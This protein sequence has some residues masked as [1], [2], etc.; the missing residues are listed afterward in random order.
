MKKIL[1]IIVLSQFLCTSLW[2]AGNAVVFDIVRD[3]EFSPNFLAHLT[4]AVQLGFITG[5]LI[6]A[7]LTIADRFSPSSVFFY[8]AI[9]A[10]LFN[11]GLVLDGLMA[12][13]MLGFRFFTGFFLAGI[14]PV[15]MKIASDYFDKGLGKSLGYLVGALVLGTSFPHLLKNFTAELPWRY[16]MYTTSALSVLGG[17]AIY[18]FVPDGHY[19]R[20]MQK[21]NFSSVIKGFEHKEF[22]AAA[23][24]YFGHMWE[25]YTFWAFLPIML[26]LYTQFNTDVVLNIPL[27]SFLIIAAGGLSCAVG[28][29][30][31]QYFGPRK[32][33][34]TALLS[35]GICCLLSPFLLFIGIPVIFV[36]FLF[37]WGLVITADSPQFSTLV[38]KNSPETSKGTNLTLVNCIGFAITI[39]SIQFIS[40]ISIWVPAQYLYLFLALGPGLG[41]LAM[42]RLRE[43]E[44]LVSSSKQKS[45]IS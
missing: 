13:Q 31:S 23:L 6:Y 36:G 29:I 4:S 24:G 18:L 10:A 2:F 40:L 17:L 12:Y 21:L 35:S 45:M 30:L 39:I 1:P 15:G 7:L 34:F 16:V 32:V 37:I 8:S 14:Y 19:R 38:A 11:L 28:G 9:L 26:T 25:L 42:W 27:L 33:A 20:P 43:K 41:I 22:K 3:M 5:T 44:S